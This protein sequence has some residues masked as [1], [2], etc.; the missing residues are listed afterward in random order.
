MNWLLLP[1]PV[2][3]AFFFVPATLPRSARQLSYGIPAGDAAAETLA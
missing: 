1:V 3:L 2:A